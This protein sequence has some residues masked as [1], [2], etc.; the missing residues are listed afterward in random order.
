M[1]IYCITVNSFS[2]IPVTRFIL[3]FLSNWYY[4]EVLECNIEGQYDLS[5]V[6]KITSLGKFK[7]SQH[8]NKQSIIFKCWKHIRIVGKLISLLFMKS[9]VIY[10]PDLQVLFYSVYIKKAFNKKGWKLIY[11][12]FELIEEKYLHGISL[13]EWRFAV[14]NIRLVNLLIFPETNRLD[15]F[16]ELVKYK[17]TNKTLLLANT[18]ESQTGQSE[19]RHEALK[20]IPETAM[21]LG[22][23][24]NVG[25]DH[26]VARF[27]SL[28]E[29]CVDY[30]NIYFVVVGRFSKEIRDQ[31]SQ[32]R[33]SNFILLGELPHY[34]L[35]RIY[36]FLNYGIILYKGVDLNFEYCAPNKLYEYWSFGIPVIAHPLTGLRNLFDSKLKGELINFENDDCILKIRTLLLNIKPDK[37]ALKQL[38]NEKLDI[39]VE[40]V[41]LQKKILVL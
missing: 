26:Y 7:S 31:F 22:H 28:V 15:Y 32:L 34:Q 36:P 5:K 21:I 17:D 2:Q 8:L 1:R 10:T 30:T 24:G 19:V 27:I 3:S 33:N 11:H 37:K 23:I 25:P 16:L 41:K 6:N 39:N 14:K 20:D 40:L 18:T 13:R 4:T 9:I 12:Q 29:M 38:F 35:K